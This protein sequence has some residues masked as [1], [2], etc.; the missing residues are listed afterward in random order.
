[1]NNAL[2][3]VASMVVEADGTTW[4]QQADEAQWADME[5]VLDPD[6]PRLGWAVRPRGYGKTR[7]LG[8]ALLAR[9]VVDLPNGSNAHGF[10]VDLAQAKLLHD[11]VRAIVE[12]TPFLRNEVRL[13]ALEA[14][15]PSRGNRITVMPSDGPGAHGLRSEHL[16]VDELGVWPEVRKSRE[17]WEAVLS[18]VQKS[19]T[20]RLTIISTPSHPDHWTMGYWERANESPAWWASHT[21]GPPAWQSPEVIEELRHTLTD[22]AFRRLVLGEFAAGADQV[23]ASEEQIEQMFRAASAQPLRVRGHYVYAAGLDLSVSGDW[24]ALSIAHL[25]QS[26]SGDQIVVVDRCRVWK[27]T[28]EK[29]LSQDRVLAE[30]LDLAEEFP[31]L[32]VNADPYQSL[33]LLERLRR[34]GVQTSTFNF[35]RQS[36]AKVAAMDLSMV[37]DGR[38]SL[39][40]H[41]D[42]LADIRAAQVVE[43]PDGSF[44][45][46]VP[47]SSRGHGD[48]LTSVELAAWH[49]LQGQPRLAQ[50]FG[51]M[52]TGGLL[53]DDPQRFLDAY[54]G[55]E[56]AYLHDAPNRRMTTHGDTRLAGRR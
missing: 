22:G 5:R 45:V 15:I 27:P 23:L 56:R 35:S 53:N 18:T 47:R 37:R 20:A 33:G 34:H 41:P 29:P 21:F 31:G 28:K 40:P 10:A 30:L 36:K 46:E 14:E 6:G 38:L 12:R 1:M 43:R 44:F 42:L 2:A 19:P 25:E 52:W 4:A 39:P 26:S 49:L 32:V 55:G 9:S 8:A 54:A 3:L 7:D 16:V 13:T 17:M 48:A 51:S 24:S 50:S 11:S